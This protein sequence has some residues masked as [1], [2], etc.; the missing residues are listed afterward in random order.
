MKLLNALGIIFSF[1]GSL[2]LAR[3][4]FISKKKALE[5]GVS[6]WASDSGEENL[7]LPAVKDRLDQ[8]IF[9]ILGAFL[10]GLGL[11]LQLAALIFYP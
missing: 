1:L 3:G 9:A 8:K 7:K 4:L 11:M 10:L 2:S 5:L 6:G